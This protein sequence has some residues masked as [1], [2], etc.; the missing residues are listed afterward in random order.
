MNYVATKLQ[1]LNASLTRVQATLAMLYTALDECAGSNVVSY[2]FSS[3]DGE[4][5]T[6]R[7]SLKDVLDMIERLEATE[8]HLINEI[9][10]MGL[11]S[12]SVRRQGP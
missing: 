2:R 6:T 9:Y 12:V 7:R 11:V 5:S 1:R 4:Q 10:G 3:S 8:E